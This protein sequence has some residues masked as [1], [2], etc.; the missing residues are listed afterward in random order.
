M[1][2]SPEQVRL[3]KQLAEYTDAVVSKEDNIGLMGH[4]PTLRKIRKAW[5]NQ[6]LT[7]SDL[8]LVLTK[9][10]RDLN[11]GDEPFKSAKHFYHEAFRGMKRQKLNPSVL[12]ALEQAALVKDILPSKKK[13]SGP[14]KK[15]AIK[16]E[17]INV[18]ALPAHLRHLV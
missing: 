15:K 13:P 8:K 2:K 10:A 1:D 6:E 16:Q 14:R 12:S 17:S 18:N 3:E 7:E 5:H 4:Q 11:G 9:L